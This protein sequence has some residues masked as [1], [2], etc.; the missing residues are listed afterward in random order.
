MAVGLITALF[1]TGKNKLSLHL[2][3]Y[4]KVPSLPY[5]ALSDRHGLEAII[6]SVPSESPEKGHLHQKY[7]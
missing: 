7:Q 2:L 3:I 5:H 1:L 6:P 4:C